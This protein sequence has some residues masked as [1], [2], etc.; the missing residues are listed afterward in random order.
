[1]RV[2]L[3]DVE[4]NACRYCE[5]GKQDHCQRWAPGVGWHTWTAPADSQRL[6]RMRAR[7]AARLTH[8]N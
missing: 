4:P 5:I 8:T 7:R 1:M 6:A 3:A 2:D